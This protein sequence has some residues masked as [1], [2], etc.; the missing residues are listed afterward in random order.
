V[1]D[2]TLELH[3]RGNSD[4]IATF[5]R[6]LCHEAVIFP[7][8]AMALYPLTGSGFTSLP[9]GGLTGYGGQAQKACL[10]L[11]ELAVHK[12]SGILQDV[13]IQRIRGSPMMG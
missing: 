7:S 13:P 5:A 12:A 10:S 6:N 9:A 8:S 1:R 4:E 2:T 3:D 11:V